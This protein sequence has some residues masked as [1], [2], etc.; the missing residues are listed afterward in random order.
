MQRPGKEEQYSV[1]RQQTINRLLARFEERY[2]KS[3]QDIRVFW[4]SR[5]S[6]SHR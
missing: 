4:G 5:A 2:G 3:E 6:Q 1:G